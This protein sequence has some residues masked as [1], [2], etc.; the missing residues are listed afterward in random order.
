MQDGFHDRMTPL[1]YCDDALVD[2]CRTYV[3]ALRSALRQRSEDVDLRDRAG[4]F[5]QFLGSAGDAVD[6]RLKELLVRAALVAPARLRLLAR[7]P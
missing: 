2:E 5:E 7:V 3:A 1:F 6:E 4:G